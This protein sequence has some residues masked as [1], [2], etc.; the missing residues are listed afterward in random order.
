[1]YI[2]CPP[3]PS[4]GCYIGAIRYPKGKGF[5]D[6]RDFIPATVAKYKEIDAAN[7]FEAKAM[8]LHLLL[9]ECK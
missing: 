8:Y 6:V 3:Y 7:V 5:E 1:M 4:K 2:D 9:K